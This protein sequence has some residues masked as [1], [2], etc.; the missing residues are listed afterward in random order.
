MAFVTAIKDYIE[1]LNNV[2]DSASGDINIQQ[3]VQ[4]TFL[5]IYASIKYILFYFISFQWL[6]DLAYLPILVPRLST[7]ILKETYFLETPISNLFTILEIPS[8]STNK[9]LVGFL[10]SFFTCLPFSAAHLICLRRFF[11]QGLPAGIASSLGTILGQV[12]FLFCV[13]FGLRLFIIPWF[14]F[15]PLSYICGIILILSIIHDMVH[16]RSIQR[17]QTSETSKLLKIFCLNFALTWT[18]QSCIFQ[19]FGNL[20]FGAEPTILENFSS[21][22]QMQSILIHGSYVV[23]MLLGSIFFTILFGFCL[24]QVTNLILRITKLTYSRWIQRLNFSLFIGIIAFSLSSVPFYGLDYLLFKPFGF[25]S[26]DSAFENTPFSSTKIADPYTFTG[27]GSFSGSKSLD[28]DVSVFDRGTYLNP[29]VPGSSDSFEGLNYQGEYAWTARKDRSKM[30]QI[31]NAR[32]L[33]S[34]FFKKTIDDTSKTD[35]KA[36]L[37]QNDVSTKISSNQKNNSEKNG[38]D[39]TIPNELFL[40]SQRKS[41]N[42]EVSDVSDLDDLIESNSNDQL[43]NSLFSLKGRLDETSPLIELFTPPLD[44]SFKNYTIDDIP[45]NSVEK[46]IKQQYYS[47][48]VYKTLLSAD[49]DSFLL[50]QPFSF[51]LSPKDEQDLFEKRILLAN[52]YDSLRYYKELPYA[53]EFQDLFSGSKSYADRI[54]N[55][56]FKGTLNIVRRLFA[57]SLDNEETLNKKLILKFDQPLYKDIKNTLNVNST[58]TTS[59]AKNLSQPDDWMPINKNNNQLAHEELSSRETKMS[60]NKQNLPFI[61]LT[62][63]IPFYTGWDEQLRKLVITNRLMPRSLA[64]YT[65]PFQTIS[66]K[67]KNNA[68]EYPSLNK[69]LT[70]TNKIEFTT[71]PLSKSFLEKPENKSTIP[72]AVLFELVENPKNPVLQEFFREWNAEGDRL[73]E[74]VPVNLNKL[75]PNKML[76]PVVPNRGG[77]VWRG[78]SSLKINFKNLL[79]NKIG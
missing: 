17:I 1:L 40:I 77:F 33:V 32:K 70:T 68:L 67:N 76:D 3:I 15:E 59:P 74:T 48:P 25:V 2:Y 10:N 11:I 51:N 49:I 47:N 30:F 69:L 56:Q 29:E 26:Q 20:T 28:T 27:L 8:Y 22:N 60:K 64:G 52:Y 4:H 62:N 41:Q 53:E 19:Y 36:K 39:N 21:T 78:Q 18:E 35:L 57:T 58:D 50:R 44:Q 12:L 66:K 34:N 31:N 16:E 61:Q 79:K 72:Y 63:P 73:I 45:E 5:Y 65:M 23:G 37:P 71:W 38:N 13:L 42:E 7:S 54:Y 6:K 9:F 14:S 75:D 55:Q 24:V 46:K 43:Q